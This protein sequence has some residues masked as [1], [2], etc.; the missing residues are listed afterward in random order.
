MENHHIVIKFKKEAIQS[1]TDESLT[2]KAFATQDNFLNQFTYRSIVTNEMLLPQQ[3]KINAINFENLVGICYVQGLNKLSVEEK[4]NLAQKMASYDFVEY[5][6]VEPPIKLPLLPIKQEVKNEQKFMGEK[7]D[8]IPDFTQLQGYK[9]AIGLDHIGIDME[10]AWSIGI[11]G[12][13]V[14]CAAIELAFNFHHVNLK[15]ESFIAL[16]T[17]FPN[18]HPNIHG[19]AVAGI[20]YGNNLGFGIKGMAHGADKFYATAVAAGPVEYVIQGLL[21]LFTRLERGDVISI[22]L[23]GPAD[24]YQSF[25]DVAKEG[26]DAGII[27]CIA[28]GNEEVDTDNNEM[29][30]EWRNRPDIG[31][32]RVGAGNGMLVRAP[33][34]SYGSRIHLQAWGRNVVTTGGYGDLYD[35]GPNKDYTDSFNGTSSAT[36]MVAS[37]AVVVQSWYKQQTDQVLSPIKMRELLIETGVPQ[38]QLVSG[39]QKH[40]GP[41]PN[42][43]NAINELRERLS[44]PIIRAVIKGPGVVYAGRKVILSAER[45]SSSAADIASYEWQIPKEITSDIVNQS[46][47]AFVV[48]ELE[49][50]KLLITLTVM[51]TLGNNNSTTYTLIVPKSPTWEMEKVYF[52]D[53]IV[54]WKNKIWIAKENH[55]HIEPGTN[56]IFWKEYKFE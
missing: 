49:S 25:W 40:I 15:R 1:K 24:Y 33:F 19:T 11:T 10:Y 4:E 16:E 14:S 27:I 39:L 12:Q 34:S 44:S 35:G 36:P 56:E 42:V 23:F 30:E 17:E 28:A 9:D 31:L 37:A 51:D 41:M 47:L 32:I 6:Y 20:L 26:L 48:P 5:A 55:I 8:G 2:L 46:T 22:S 13:G 43:R 7:T 54:S 29:F 53:D 3:K 50:Q 21:K 45:S 18:T 38:T 52:I